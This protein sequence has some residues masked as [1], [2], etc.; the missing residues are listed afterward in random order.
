MTF[1]AIFAVILLIF[2]GRSMLRWIAG[3]VRLWRRFDGR[4]LP[5]EHWRR[6]ALAAALI[7]AVELVL[8][9]TALTG[10]AEIPDAPRIDLWSGP[11]QDA[12]AAPTLAEAAAQTPW[13]ARLTWY[14]PEREAKLREVVTWAAA[15]SRVQAGGAALVSGLAGVDPAALAQAARGPFADPNADPVTTSIYVRQIAWSVPEGIAGLVQSDPLPDPGARW[16]AAPP[17]LAAKIDKRYGPPAVMGPAEGGL[18]ARLEGAALRLTGDRRDMGPVRDAMICRA[19]TTAAGAVE[20]VCRVSIHLPMVYDTYAPDCAGPDCV[21]RWTRPLLVLR[22][23]PG[24]VEIARPESVT[25]VDPSTS[26]ALTWDGETRE[27]GPVFVLTGAEARAFAAAEDLRATHRKAADAQGLLW[28]RR[29]PFAWPP[30]PRLVAQSAP[31][32]GAEARVP[33]PLL[34]EAAAIAGLGTQGLAAAVAS[35]G[36]TGR[37]LTQSADLVHE[38]AP[39]IRSNPRARCG[40]TWRPRLSVAPELRREGTTRTLGNKVLD[41]I[42][43]SRSWDWE[44]LVDPVQN[45][46]ACA[47]A[48]LSLW[49]MSGAIDALSG[50]GPRIAPDAPDP[51]PR[52]PTAADLKAERAAAAQARPSARSAETS[53]AAA[54]D[55][56]S[57][58]AAE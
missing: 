5:T 16:T 37:L 39:I 28:A 14:T 24:R 20:P 58:S 7:A 55:S 6:L 3:Q 21:R 54:P 22:L 31:F 18:R 47:W 38:D 9:S 17:L 8:P 57:S 56:A 33:T 32:A 48:Q 53:D 27:I 1:L 43:A 44:A 13:L 19:E 23:S 2:S 50:R 12:A 26:W 25:G 4:D 36:K 41:P 49:S 34:H 45:P 29:K 46:E 15:A 30:G 40:L 51:A 42:V 52:P 10:R 35:I 11:A